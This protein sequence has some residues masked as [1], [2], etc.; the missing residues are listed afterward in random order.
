MSVL[1]TSASCH[2]VRPIEP[3]LDACWTS[4]S[5]VVL[6][7]DK[8]YESDPLDAALRC[9]GTEMVSPHTT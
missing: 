2:E 8:T 6:T 1:I 3:A 7:G 5:P 9:R 4:G